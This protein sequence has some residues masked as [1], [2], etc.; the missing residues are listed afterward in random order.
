MEPTI[1]LSNLAVS[2]AMGRNWA[3]VA[4]TRGDPITNWSCKTGQRA[5]CRSS[6]PWIPN[7]IYTVLLRCSCSPWRCRLRPLARASP[8]ACALYWIGTWMRRPPRG[9]APPRTSSGAAYDAY[10]ARA[11]RFILSRYGHRR[12]SSPLLSNPIPRSSPPSRPSTPWPAR[13]RRRSRQGVQILS[14]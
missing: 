10:A 13:R 6:A 2:R 5:R 4:R 8:S 12:D 11:K 9:E 3:I 14:N 7:P 1:G